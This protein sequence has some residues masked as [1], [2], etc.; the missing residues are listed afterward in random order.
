MRLEGTLRGIAGVNLFQSALTGW[1]PMM[2]VLGR[3]GVGRE[4]AAAG[5]GAT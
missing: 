3:L 5:G 2:A 4:P 1:G